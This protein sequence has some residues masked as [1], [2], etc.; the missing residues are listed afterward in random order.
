LTF[1]GRALKIVRLV[2]DALTASGV[3]GSEHLAAFLRS[4]RNA[5]GTITLE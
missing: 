5:D 1:N 4:F 3:V 2:A